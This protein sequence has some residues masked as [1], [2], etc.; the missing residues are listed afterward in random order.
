M[1]KTKK[2]FTADSLF[3]I[4]NGLFMICVALIMIYPVYYVLAASFSD[5]ARLV[6]HKGILL[7]PLSFSVAAY[8]NISKNPMIVRSYMNTIFIVVVGVSINLIMTSFAA[9]FLSRKN[10]VFQKFIMIFI[11]VTMYFSGGTIPYYFAVKSLGLNDTL[12]SIIIP[13]AIN[14]FNMII[15]KSAFE[16]IPSSLEE[17]AKIDGAGHFTILFKIIIPVSKATMAVMVLYYAVAHWNAWFNAMLFINTREKFPLQ[18]VLREILVQGDTSAMTQSISNADQ[19]YISE[20]IKYAVIVVATLPIL[21][22]YPF[23]QK[24]FVQGVMIGSIKG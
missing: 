18:L 8:K 24:Y 19:A 15:M 22:I 13:G 9:Y 4:V 20:T 10:L 17:S 7:K 21:C 3:S 12:W 6:A 23:L 5:A 16:E 11:M 2:I 1:R 14:T